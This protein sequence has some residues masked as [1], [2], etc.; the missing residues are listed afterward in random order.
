M[1]HIG[2]KGEGS[3]GK[4]KADN[5]DGPG[6]RFMLPLASLADTTGDRKIPRPWKWYWPGKGASE[7]WSSPVTC[8]EFVLSAMMGEPWYM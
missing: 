1:N 8:I 2:G 6:I 5:A 7:I 4:D 3:V